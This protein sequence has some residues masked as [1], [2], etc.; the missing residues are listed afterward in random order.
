MTR[1]GRWRCT[2]GVVCILLLAAA[3]NRTPVAVRAERLAPLPRGEVRYVAV[4]PFEAAPEVGADPFE[5]GQ[6]VRGEAPATTI[7]RA[8]TDAMLVLPGWKVTDDLVVGE[9][10][11]KLFG[12]IRPVGPEEAAQVGRLLGVDGVLYGIVRR[13]ETRVGAEYAAQRPA[14]VDFEVA[15]TLFP[16]GEAVWRAEFVE[17]QRPLS[18]DLS[19]LFGFVRARGRWLRAGELASIGAG[20]VVGEMHHALYGG[21]AT[22]IPAREW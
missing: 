5:P 21:A 8:V 16:A 2:G 12:T 3:C 9:A 6:E 20:Q 1:V 10:I 18:E 14:L 19:N 7:H 4:L 22:P 11:R 13:F 15:L 17:Q